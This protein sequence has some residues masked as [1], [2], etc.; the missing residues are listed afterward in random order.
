MNQIHLLRTM[1]VFT[2]KNKNCSGKVYSAKNSC[3]QNAILIQLNEFIYNIYFVFFILSLSMASQGNKP[4]VCLFR[5][6]L[7]L[8]NILSSFS[9]TSLIHTCL[10][11]HTSVSVFYQIIWP[12]VFSISTKDIADNVWGLLENIFCISWQGS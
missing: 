9:L 4:L 6:Y 11:F 1:S 12:S 5:E 10:L 7:L 2:R 3:F 8:P